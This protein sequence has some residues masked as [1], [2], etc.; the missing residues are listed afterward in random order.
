MY[1]GIKF[2]DMATISPITPPIK[3]PNIPN[4]LPNNTEGT[5]IIANG[6]S[7]VKAVMPILDIQG[8]STR[9][10]ASKVKGYPQ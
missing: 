7:H 8:T 9:V 1:E 6:N 10:L 2:A 5:I 4:D 3:N